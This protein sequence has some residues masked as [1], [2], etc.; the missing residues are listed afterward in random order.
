MQTD[1]QTRLSFLQLLCEHAYKLVCH[2][3]PHA[4]AQIL[5]LSDQQGQIIRITIFYEVNGMKI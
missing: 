3:E 1:G 2:E 5:L 4:W